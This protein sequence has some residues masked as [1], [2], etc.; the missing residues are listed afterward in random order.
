MVAYKQMK[1]VAVAE[2]W[3]ED[4]SVAVLKAYLPRTVSCARLYHSNRSDMHGVSAIRKR[5]CARWPSALPAAGDASPRRSRPA[6]LF[7]VPRRG[8]GNKV[9]SH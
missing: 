1:A 9:V 2:N 8:S 6:L 3:R 7:L 4:R 5:S